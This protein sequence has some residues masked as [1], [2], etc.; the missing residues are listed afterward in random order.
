MSAPFG[1]RVAVVVSRVELG[2]YVVLEVADD[3]TP[4]A[5]GQF[6]MLAAVERWGGGEDE[7]PFLGRAISALA[8]RGERRAGDEASV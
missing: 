7:R 2:A 1:R 3:A 4:A 6:Y 5:P 8:A